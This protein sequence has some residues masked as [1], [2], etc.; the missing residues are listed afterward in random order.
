VKNYSASPTLCVGIPTYNRP[1][2]LCRRIH[3]IN[4]FPDLITEILICDNSNTN[5]EMVISSIKNSKIKCTYIKNIANIGAGANFL[6]VLE[7]TESDY[8]WWRGDDDV[9]SK[10]QVD[11]VKENISS[12]PGLLLMSYTAREKFISSGIDSFVSNFEK[13]EAMTWAS[14][15]I[16]PT[17]L[18]KIELSWGY[19]IIDW[20]HVA[21]II[22]MISINSSLKFS[23]IPYELKKNHFRDIGRVGLGWPF[24]NTTLKK[25]PQTAE[26]VPNRLRQKY[27]ENW[28]KTKK[29]SLVRTMIGMKM[30]VS[31]QE[32]ISLS[33]FSSLISVKN[34]YCNFVAITLFLASKVPSTIYLLLFSFAWKWFSASRKESFSLD[35]LMPCT[36]F[37]QVY[38]E[39]RKNLRVMPIE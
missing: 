26:I 14:Q 17:R 9:I 10:E 36:N 28:R 15:V 20:A 29:L 35:F 5:T 33:T 31:T 23:V 24:F 19:K 8:L 16:V 7:N 21:L 11:A 4:N 38:N 12:D 6:R 2:A 18:A 22:R 1:E 39:L 25:F 32:T 27:L 34:L 30:G 3:E 13:I 37:I